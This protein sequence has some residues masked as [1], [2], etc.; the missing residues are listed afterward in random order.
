[1]PVKKDRYNEELDL[2]PEDY[3]FMNEVLTDEDIYWEYPV[4]KIKDGLMQWII[5]EMLERNFYP[6]DYEEEGEQ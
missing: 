2:Y 1:M 6:N 3:E 4:Y 5:Q